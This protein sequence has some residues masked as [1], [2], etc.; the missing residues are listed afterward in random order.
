VSTP[1]ILSQVT[2]DTARARRV[3]PVTS[4]EAADSISA[5]HLEAS[6]REVLTILASFDEPVIDQVIVK[7]HLVRAWQH[8]DVPLWTE[9]RIRTARVQL[10]K[11]G[12][13]VQDG[14]GRTEKGRKANAW[15]L[16]P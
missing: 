5:E 3:D 16:A 13:V 2:G 4:H 12:A 15:R 10:T 8:A 14:V 11:K 1:A 6:E 7:R 9:Q